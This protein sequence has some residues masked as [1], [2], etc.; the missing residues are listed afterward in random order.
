MKPKPY[1]SFVALILCLAWTNNLNKAP[2]VKPRTPPPRLD[3]PEQSL[4]PGAT[5][6]PPKLQSSA[7]TIYS[8]TNAVMALPYVRQA[9]MS[10]FGEGIQFGIAASIQNRSLVEM[11]NA[12][13]L[14]KIAMW[15]RFGK[16]QK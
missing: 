4:M 1:L 9:L 11:Q 13:E 2:V 3:S 16:G 8:D 6:G 12:Q 15:L 10:A 14:Q 5:N 7:L